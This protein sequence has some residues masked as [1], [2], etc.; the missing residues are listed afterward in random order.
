MQYKIQGDPMPVVICQLAPGEKMITESGSMVWMSPGFQMETA[1]GG[2]GKAFGRMFTGES[3]FQNY[4]TAPQTGGMI[5]FGASFVGAIRA[6]EITP[7]RPIIAQKRAFL[8]STSG[9]ELSTFFQKRAAAGFFGGEGFIMQRLSGSGIA[10]LEVDGTAVEYDLA[11]GQQLLVSTGNL[12]LCDASCSIDIQ[13]VKGLKNKLL[14][15]EGFFN[16]VVTGPG[17]ITLQTMSLQ[18]FASTVAA[19]IPKGNG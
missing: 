10:F 13:A 1:A 7:D 16:T 18:Q 4:Y 9:V 14:G 11:A 12:A 17:R 5:A 3:V 15:G 19:Y 2:V 6:V 8:A